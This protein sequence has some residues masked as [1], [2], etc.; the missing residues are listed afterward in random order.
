MPAIIKGM[1]NQM[2]ADGIMADGCV[3]LQPI[4][5][6]IKTEQPVNASIVTGKYK[7]DIVRGIRIASKVAT[8]AVIMG[9]VSKLSA[10]Q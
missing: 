7:D 3:G 2:K 8:P 9:P 10:Q 6:V 4:Y 5:E 1:I